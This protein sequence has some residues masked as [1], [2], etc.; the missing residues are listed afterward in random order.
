[1]GEFR[2]ESVVLTSKDMFLYSIS[3][4]SIFIIGIIFFVKFIINNKVYLRKSYN[5]SKMM[6]IN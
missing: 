4:I 2:N 5:K 3:G 1:L 6:T